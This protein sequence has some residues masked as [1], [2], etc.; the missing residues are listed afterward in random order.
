MCQ[1]VFPFGS[2]LRV[3]KVVVLCSSFGVH[4]WA[5]GIF[6]YINGLVVFFGTSMGL[7][8]ILVVSDSEYKRIVVQDWCSEWRTGFVWSFLGNPARPKTPSSGN[9]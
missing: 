8:Y 3:S 2:C 4:Y 5:C 6:W 7:W 1:R 9:I